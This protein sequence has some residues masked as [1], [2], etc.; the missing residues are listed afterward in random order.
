LEDRFAKGSTIITSQLPIK[1]WYEYIPHP[2]I[3]LFGMIVLA[4][5]FTYLLPLT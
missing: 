3:I 4:W 5:L 1:K 2:V